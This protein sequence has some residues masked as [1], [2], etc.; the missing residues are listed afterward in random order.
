MPRKE[1]KLG[2]LNTLGSANS[3]RKPVARGSHAPARSNGS[4]ARRSA[5]VVAAIE[6]PP[7]AAPA[8]AKT[9]EPHFQSAKFLGAAG[10]TRRIA[11]INIAAFA[12]LM[13]ALALGVAAAYA[14]VPR[15]GLFIA[16]AG[17][18]AVVIVASVWILVCAGIRRLHDMNRS[19]LWL[20]T[21]LIPAVNALLLLALVIWPGHKGENQFG[22]PARR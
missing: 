9:P 19:G 21:V 3:P 17:G 18:F 8:G 22:A 5:P 2:D 1:P 11:F 10:R 12:L 14:D 13:I 20:L 4:A 16:K 6:S 15:D 7:P